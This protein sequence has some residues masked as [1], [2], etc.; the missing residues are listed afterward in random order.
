M[1]AMCDQFQ[2]AIRVRCNNDLK[3]VN[4]EAINHL[5]SLKITQ[6]NQ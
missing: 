5:R 3:K 6:Q 4:K 1:P 2:K